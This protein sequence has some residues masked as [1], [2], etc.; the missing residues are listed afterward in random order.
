MSE[1]GNVGSSDYRERFLDSLW[2][3]YAIF[4]QK[5]GKIWH[6]SGTGYTFYFYTWNCFKK[7]VLD[8]NLKKLFTT[9]LNQQINKTRLRDITSPTYSPNRNN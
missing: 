9:I 5:D 1:V 6:I 7:L 4:M 8:K 3:F 2:T